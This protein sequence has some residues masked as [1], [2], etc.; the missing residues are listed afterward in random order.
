VEALYAD[1]LPELEVR[2]RDRTSMRSAFVDFKGIEVPSPFLLLG[3]W[4]FNNCSQI[5]MH[6]G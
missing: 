1:V 5:Q 2:A 3:G 6:D 4:E